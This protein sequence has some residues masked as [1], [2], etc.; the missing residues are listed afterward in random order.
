MADFTRLPAFAE[1]G[2]V[3]VVIE[4]PRG[5]R[6]K[7]KFEPALQA[8]MLS[9]AL[10]LGLVYPY[11]WGFI[12]STAAPDGDPLDALV[13]HDSETFPGAVMRCK[14][15]GILEVMQTEKSKRVRNDRVFF[16]P[17]DGRDS[18][19]IADICELSR[20]EKEQLQEFFRAVVS[21]TEKTLK[22]LGWRG[23]KNALA[24]VRSSTKQFQQTG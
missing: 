11:D 4:T 2:G 18:A 22:F 9:R 12:P 19:S 6:V 5:A 7:Y 16:V 8:F 13:I 1:D 15:I 3:H 10:T 14:P 23:S 20:L 24:A 21:T 17:H